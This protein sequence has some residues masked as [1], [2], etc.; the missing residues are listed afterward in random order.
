MA[1]SARSRSLSLPQQALGL[2]SLFPDSQVTLREPHLRWVGDLHP[3]ELSPPYRTRID[4]ELGQYP[5][6]KVIDPPITETYQRIP[7]IY[8]SGALCVHDAKDWSPRM[9]LVDT[10]VAWTIEWLYFWELYLA[11]CIWYGDGPNTDIAD[12]SSAEDLPPLPEHK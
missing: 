11:T 8:N 2:R 10:I 5:T 9:L 3:T 6:V 7:H 12:R 1:M 4:Y